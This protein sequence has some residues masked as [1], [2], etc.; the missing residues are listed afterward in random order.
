VP[1]RL[2][3]PV[4]LLATLL[5]AAPA[6]AATA[7][8]LPDRSSGLESGYTEVAPGA[9]LFHVLA[10]SQRPGAPLVVYVA[11]GPGASSMTPIFVGNGPWRL[12]APFQP[13]RAEVTRNPWSW[14]RLANVV[15]VDQPRHTGF[16]RG[17]APYLTSVHAAGRDFAAWLRAFR[18]DHPQLARR[19]LLLAG[20]SFAGTYLSEFARRV[21]DGDAGRGLRLG[22][23]FLEAPS[24][25]DTEQ[26]PA[27]TQ[28]DF[29]CRRRLVS[30]AS[31]VAGAPGGIRT[32]LQ[33]CAVTTGATS[34][35]VTL[36]Q[37]KRARGA[38]CAAYRREVTTQPGRTRT[39]PFPD[40]PLLPA[41]LR[42][43]PIPEPLDTRLFPRGGLVRRHL[44]FSPNPYDVRLP[45]RP[46]GGFPPWC[47]DDAKLTA[48]LNAPATRSWIG[49]G[50][51]PER[52]WRFADFRV[53]VALTFKSR[54]PANGNYARALRAGVPVLLAFGAA[55][56]DINPLAARHLV[57]DIARR[58]G[59]ASRRLTHV[60]L[61]G[62]GH[63]LGL[64]RPRTTYRLMARFLARAR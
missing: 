18:A 36:R 39:R 34:S 64:D 59:A 23:L 4:L 58:A 60:E 49:G 35:T 42:G 48:L 21:L 55:D 9:H 63:M 24:L 25:G 12:R 38:A 2:G 28:P 41:E 40:S 44:G 15:Y 22:G 53:S 5:C 46:S 7:P 56:W 54:L 27:R 3:L 37:I 43:T 52:R 8:A 29:L 16:S 30:A 31:C 13:G 61:P 20:E 1:L 51:P 50:I 47:Y 45:C 10:R 62:A 14:T 33:A 26:A 17:S 6:P 19:R 11:G 57:R 32:L